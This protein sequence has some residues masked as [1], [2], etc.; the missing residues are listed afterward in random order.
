MI[1][2]SVAGLTRLVPAA[3]GKK[4]LKFLLTIADRKPNQFDGAAVLL[5]MGCDRSQ[6]MDGSRVTRAPRQQLLIKRDCLCQGAALVKGG[7]SLKCNLCGDTQLAW[8]FRFHPVLG[9]AWS[10]VT[11]GFASRSILRQT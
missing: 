5:L 11:D 3:R 8:M 10:I 2:P 4:A 1:R 6:T 7:R 9:L